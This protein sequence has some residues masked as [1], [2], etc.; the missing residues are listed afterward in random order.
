LNPGTDQRYISAAYEENTWKRVNAAKNCL[1][2]FAKET[3][4]HVT[5][6]LNSNTTLYF[7][8]WALSKKGLSH[9]TVKAYLNNI[10]LIHKLKEKDNSACNTFLIKTTLKGAEN[11]AMY[12]N[13]GSNSK[14]T[15]SIQL[16]QKIGSKIAK[17]NISKRDKQVYWTSCMTAFWGS[18]RMG[19]ILAK[20]QNGIDRES[21]TWKDIKLDRDFATVLIKRPKVNKTE[22]DIVNLFAVEGLKLPYKSTKKTSRTDR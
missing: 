11:L 19:K 5:W 6:P 7:T 14:A 4:T 2:R 16:L 20:N 22:T 1:K 13:E 15:I 3:Q 21:L 17:S 9:S 8:N 12:K 10:S 18:F